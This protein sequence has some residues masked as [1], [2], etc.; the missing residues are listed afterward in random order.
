MAE[1]VYYGEATEDSAMREQRRQEQGIGVVGAGSRSHGH[2]L[3]RLRIKS[4]DIRVRHSIKANGSGSFSYSVTLSGL[5]ESEVIPLL[6]FQEQQRNNGVP[7]VTN[8]SRS[9]EPTTDPNP[10]KPSRSKKSPA[11]MVSL[12]ELP[13]DVQE[14]MLAQ[15]KVKERAEVHP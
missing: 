14:K 8:E 7:Q 12:D 10:Q 6:K 5:L 15:I 11:G 3:K 2:G 9:P 4:K 13:P 1:K